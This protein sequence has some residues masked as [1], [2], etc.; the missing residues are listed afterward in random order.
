M[1]TKTVTPAALLASPDTA[2]AAAIEAAQADLQRQIAADHAEWES[3]AKQGSTMGAKRRA[4]VEA[5]DID[6]IIK[7]DAQAEVLQAKVDLMRDQHRALSELRKTVFAR[8]SVDNLPKAYAALTATLERLAKLGAEVLA[9]WEQ[10]GASLEAIEQMRRAV[11]ADAPA[12]DPA[13]AVALQAAWAG[14][15]PPQPSSTP[16]DP[17]TRGN[18]A[19][20]LGLV[21]AVHDAGGMRSTQVRAA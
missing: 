11:D 15:Q 7:N 1:T 3:I 13:L 12:P 4:L 14:A 18:V 21:A 8:E 19:R 16:F 20:A 6:A 2:T 5:G 9:G 17:G 10:V